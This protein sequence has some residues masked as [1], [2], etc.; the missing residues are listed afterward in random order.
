MLWRREGEVRA[1]VVAVQGFGFQALIEDD[2]SAVYCRTKCPLFVDLR[3]IVL[4]KADFVALPRSSVVV[5]VV[6][7]AG[8]VVDFAPVAVVV[9]VMRRI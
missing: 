8:V 3:R 2:S 9:L 4:S 7:A 6:A 1:P 5:V